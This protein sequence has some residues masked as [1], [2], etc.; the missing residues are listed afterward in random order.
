MVYQLQ[1]I[2]TN[3]YSIMIIHI[4]YRIDLIFL[5][6]IIYNCAYVWI[7]LITT[8]IWFISSYI[9]SHFNCVI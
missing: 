1:K 2:I 4:A 7:Y 9:Y 3:I 5:G 6:V 8:P